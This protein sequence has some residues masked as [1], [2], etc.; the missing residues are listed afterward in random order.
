MY[1][2]I[3]VVGTMGNSPCCLL[4][5]LAWHMVIILCCIG[6]GLYT[7]IYFLFLDDKR[8]VVMA[9]VS[10]GPIYIYSSYSSG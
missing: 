5:W 10:I 9:V 2:L 3:L 7:V 6:S 8:D 4:P 1:S